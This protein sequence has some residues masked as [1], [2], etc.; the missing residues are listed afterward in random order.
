MEVKKMK[1]N[2]NQKGKITITTIIVFIVVFYGGFVAFKIITSRLTKAQ[3]KNEIVDKF[4][5]VRGAD[6]TPEKGREI[7]EEVMEDHGFLTPDEIRPRE[8]SD[9]DTYR[10]ESETEGESAVAREGTKIFVEVR[11]KGAKAWFRVEY[12][13]IIDLILFNQKARYSF[14]DE[15]INYN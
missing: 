14:E 12:T 13:D 2:A 8:E 7:I 4:G 11:D 5:F 1:G 10:D 9:E 3:I 15:V 6:F